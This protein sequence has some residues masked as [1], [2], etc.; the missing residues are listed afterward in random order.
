MRLVLSALLLIGL[1]A[2]ATSGEPVAAQEGASTGSVERGAELF[3]VGCATCHGADGQGID[4]WPAIAG[5]GEAAAD[6][7]LRTGRMPYTGEPG[8]QTQPKPPAYDEEEIADLV[9]FVGSLG[10]GPAIP[11]FE[12]DDALLQQGYQLFA[13]NCAPCHGATASGGAVGGGAIA[14]PLTDVDARTVGEAMLTG[15]GQM[16]VFDLGD[17]SMAA[18]ATYIGFL[19]TSGDPGGFE[20]GGI[21]PVPEGFVAWLVGMGLL[22]GVVYLVGRRWD[23]TGHR[24]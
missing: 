23:R 1:L 10:D 18:V 4:P 6:F 14:W 3:R 16:P 9:A 2:V 22:I 11:A 20:I 8:Q 15:P 13:A 5:A 12:T 17:E 21:G 7:Q 24:E 19:Q